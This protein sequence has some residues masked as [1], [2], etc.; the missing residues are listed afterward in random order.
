MEIKGM[1]IKKREIY[2]SG[3]GKKYKIDS[4][5]TSLSFSVNINNI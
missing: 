4:T 5:H 2:T 1:I 3:G